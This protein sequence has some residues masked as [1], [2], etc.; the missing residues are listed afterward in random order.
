MTAMANAVEATVECGIVARPPMTCSRTSEVARSFRPGLPTT[1]R[2]V[3]RSCSPPIEATATRPWQRWP[4][5][6][7]TTGITATRQPGLVPSRALAVAR[8]RWRG[9]RSTCLRRG[10]DGH[11]RG[12]GRTEPRRSRSG[13]RGRA[14]LVARRRRESARPAGA[15]PSRPRPRLGDRHAPR[16]RGGDRRARGSAARSL[17]DFESVLAGRLAQSDLFGHALVTID[18][19]AVL[20]PDLLPEGAVEAA[21][22]RPRAAGA[23]PLLARLAPA[24]VPA[25]S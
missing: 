25:T 21:R 3:R 8:A 4:A 17:G 16:D 13:A 20:P 18:A 12:A 9:D 14:A 22:R 5:S 1:S 19:T 2:A 6:A 10:D 15:R 24:E 23:V 7:R 11:R